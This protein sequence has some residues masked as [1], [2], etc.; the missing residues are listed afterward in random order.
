LYLYTYTEF[1][2]II[3]TSAYL[4]ANPLPIPFLFWCLCAPSLTIVSPLIKLV[5][6]IKHKIL[7]KLRDDIKKQTDRL[8][9]NGGGHKCSGSHFT[10]SRPEFQAV[11]HI[12]YPFPDTPKW[13]EGWGDHMQKGGKIIFNHLLFP[14]LCF[15]YC[16]IYTFSRTLS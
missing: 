8:V 10:F 16:R 11:Q 9:D 4:G 14:K 2:H 1:E 13:G 7:E 15:N 12:Q 6:L 3:K 5:Y